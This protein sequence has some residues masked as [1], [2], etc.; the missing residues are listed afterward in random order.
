MSDDRGQDVTKI[1]LDTT[2]DR[3]ESEG[4][5]D[6]PI[7]DAESFEATKRLI[8]N[9]STKLDELKG[10]QKDLRGRLKN[11][12]DNDVALSEY[13]QQAKDAASEFTKRKKDLMESVEAKEIRAKS[14]EVAEEIGDMQD[15]LTHHL[16]SYYQVTGVQSFETASGEEREFKFNAKLMPAK[17]R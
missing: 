15:S 14:K 8:Q 3:G 9:I 5:G 4:M 1:E 10:K 11:I 17:E 16:I 7:L 13:E 12:L 2:G 6:S